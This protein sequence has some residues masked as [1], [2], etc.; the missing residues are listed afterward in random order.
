MPIIYSIAICTYNRG[1]VIKH[2]IE[3]ALKLN[4][5]KDKYEIIVVDNNS[6]DDTRQIV[7]GYISSN[8]NIRIVEEK[9]Q[10]ASFARNRAYN[11]ARG[12]YIIYIDDDAEMCPDYLKNLE[13]VIN[14]EED[15]AA[16]GGPIEV[17]WLGAVPDWYEPDL[18][19]VFNYLYIASYRIRVFYPRMIYGTNM[20]IKVSI[21]K[22]I[23]GF[24]TNLGPKKK[25]PLVG[26]DV[27]I[28]LRIEK[29]E[30]KPIY[31][32]PGLKVKHLICPERLNQDYIIKK[33]E[34]HGRSQF[35]FENIHGI[36]VGYGL[37]LWVLFQSCIRT[38][39]GRGRGKIS[40]KSYRSWSKGYMKQ[41]WAHLWRRETYNK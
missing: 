26:E 36:K 21:L 6:T 18:D 41:W 11:E 35:I 27:E 10:G 7:E 5:D 32:D 22:K 37:A 25:H 19:F 4:F 28:I 14:E 1:S 30:K 2:S 39:V 23:G 38:L 34:W 40:E 20:V 13:S 12:E 24:N 29:N 31:Y 33:T 3:S 8:T 15:V 9:N 17:G 16:A